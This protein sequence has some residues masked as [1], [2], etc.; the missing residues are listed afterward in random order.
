MNHDFRIKVPITVISRIL[1]HINRR[2]V[3]HSRILIILLGV[4]LDPKAIPIVAKQIFLNKFGIR[5]FNP[6][7]AAI[8]QNIAGPIM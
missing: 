2:L 8:V 3:G 5:T 7:R 6:Q 1:K 4:M